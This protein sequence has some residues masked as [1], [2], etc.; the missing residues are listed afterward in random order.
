M[1]KGISVVHGLLHHVKPIPNA[2]HTKVVQY[3]VGDK[4]SSLQRAFRLRIELIHVIDNAIRGLT[5]IVDNEASQGK[6][7]GEHKKAFLK[8]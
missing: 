5:I 4:L 2:R 1:R 8:M 3:N 7:E 6:L